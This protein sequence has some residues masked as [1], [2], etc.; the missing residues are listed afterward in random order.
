MVANIILLFL[1][2]YVV[3]NESQGAVIEGLFIPGCSDCT[4]KAK[5]QAVG[6]VGAVIMPHN[7]YLHSALV[8][9]AT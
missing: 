9:V 4:S 3:V 5:K 6:I 1:L 8:K 7:F 2:Q